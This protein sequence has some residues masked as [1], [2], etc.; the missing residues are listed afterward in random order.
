RAPNLD[1]ARRQLSPPASAPGQTTGRCTHTARRQGSAASDSCCSL[2]W[3]TGRRHGRG[4]AEPLLRRHERN[5][6]LPGPCVLTHEGP[7]L[8]SETSVGST[9]QSSFPSAGG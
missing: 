1:L 3:A 9:R 2:L 8:Q 5:R 7:P 6:S 4:V